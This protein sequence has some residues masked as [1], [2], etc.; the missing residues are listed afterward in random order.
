MC[1]TQEED[2][3][4]PM[5]VSDFNFEKFSKSYG[6]PGEFGFLYPPPPLRVSGKIPDFT[7]KTLYKEDVRENFR[8]KLENPISSVNF[9]IFR[10]DMA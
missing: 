1:Q 3:S 4:L 10:P 5:V 2:L 7:L 9:R 8:K 6:R